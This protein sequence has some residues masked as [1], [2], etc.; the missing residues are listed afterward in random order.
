MTQDNQDPTGG[1]GTGMGAGDD[2]TPYQATN[3]ILG[4]KSVTLDQGAEGRAWNVIRALRKPRGAS[5]SL[6]GQAGLFH[7]RA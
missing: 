2:P 3:R 1:G 4:I 6:G 5:R 7:Q